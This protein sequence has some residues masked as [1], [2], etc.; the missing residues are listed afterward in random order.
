[1]VRGRM[2]I[3]DRIAAFH[4][5]QSITNILS[6]VI[7]SHIH[8]CRQGGAGTMCH[9]LFIP[10]LEESRVAHDQTETRPRSRRSI[11]ARP[12]RPSVRR[13][14]TGTRPA[15]QPNLPR[16]FTESSL[17]NDNTDRGEQ[18]ANCNGRAS[19][20]ERSGSLSLPSF[21]IECAFSLHLTVGPKIC[22]CQ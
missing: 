20:R 15:G 22:P 8:S 5:D 21:Q 18:S 14:V 17:Q 16:E 13:A 7:W 19:E 2:T 9:H 10:L 4:K 11:E 6:I 12:I 1:M 3:I